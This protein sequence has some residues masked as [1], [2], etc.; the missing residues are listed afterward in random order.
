MALYYSGVTGKD[1]RTSVEFQI[2]PSVIVEGNVLG[3]WLGE[4]WRF[5]F[6]VRQ[7][8]NADMIRVGQDGGRPWAT[9]GHSAYIGEDGGLFSRRIQAP[10]TFWSDTAAWAKP[11]DLSPG[12]WNVL[13]VIVIGDTGM[14]AG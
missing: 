11:L 9:W 4:T 13:E 12:A 3:D 7:T 10:E 1:V 8:D 6:T 5:G 2:P 14:F